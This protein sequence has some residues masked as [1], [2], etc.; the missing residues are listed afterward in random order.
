[1]GDPK[2][3]EGFF[4]G[5]LDSYTRFGDTAQNKDEAHSVQCGGIDMFALERLEQEGRQTYDMIVPYFE[6]HGLTPSFQTRKHIITLTR[7]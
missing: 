2:C 7:M 3:R 1:M 5:K 4:D 6:S